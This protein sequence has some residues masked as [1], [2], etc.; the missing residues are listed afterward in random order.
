MLLCDLNEYE[1]V[2]S[3]FQVGAATVTSH[4][5][6]GPCLATLDHMMVTF[7]TLSRAAH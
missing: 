1:K 2:V 5:I 3:R 7:V 6:T 4:W